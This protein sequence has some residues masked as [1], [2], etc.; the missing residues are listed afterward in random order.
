MKLKQLLLW[1]KAIANLNSI[2]KS[3]D[4]TLPTKVRLVKA[5]VFPVV[6]YG[7]AAAS[8]AKSLQSCLT[9]CGP[10][11]CSMLGFTDLHYLSEF[12]QTHVHWVSDT[13][14]PSHPLSSLSPP[15]FKISHHQDLFQWVSSWHQVAKVLGVSAS[16]LPKNT[17]DWS[18]LGWTGWTSL[19]SKGL[20]GVFSNTKV[21]KHQF[22]SIQLSLWSNSHF[23]I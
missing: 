20:S 1:R 23:H 6:M 21:Q 19:Q 4:I 16:V 5:M 11:D 15:A 13:T 7:C 17:Q 10:M 2:L 3:R 8:P 18:P 9:L 12:V 22:F 14:Q